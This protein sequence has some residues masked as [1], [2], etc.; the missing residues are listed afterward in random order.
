MNVAVVAV[1]HA[2]AVEVAAT[3]G[4]TGKSVPLRSNVDPL[5]GHRF[6]SVVVVTR[7]GLSVDTGW[8]SELLRRN[9]GPVFTLDRWGR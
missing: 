8:W 1:T 2:E 6:T 9:G 4:M 5:L 7:P 3:L